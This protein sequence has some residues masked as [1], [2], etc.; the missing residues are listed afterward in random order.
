MKKNPC[1]FIL[2]ALLLRIKL[3]NTILKGT[4]KDNL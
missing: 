1:F 2:G 4:F 3:E